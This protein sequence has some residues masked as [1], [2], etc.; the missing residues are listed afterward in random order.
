MLPKRISPPSQLDDGQDD[1]G[2]RDIEDPEA[3]HR[4][5]WPPITADGEREQADVQHPQEEQCGRPSR[6][7]L[8]Q[9]L[10]IYDRIHALADLIF[11]LG[12]SMHIWR[13]VY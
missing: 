12:H 11:A 7:P 9:R 8:L 2:R 1:D 3:Q 4:G 10:F 6:S 5:Q 13:E